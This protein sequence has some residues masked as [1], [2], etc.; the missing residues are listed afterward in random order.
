MAT[1]VAYLASPAAQSV[2]GQLFGVRGREVFLFAQPRPAGRIVKQDGDW[3]VADLAAAVDTE[4][5]PSF[6]ALTT[7]LEAFNTDPVV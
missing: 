7:D 5:A 6:A 3:N 2:T 1:F 4:L